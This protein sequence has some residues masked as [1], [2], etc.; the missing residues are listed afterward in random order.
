MGVGCQRHAQASLPWERP[1]TH[2]IL[3]IHFFRL[4]WS[5]LYFK[6]CFGDFN[7][8]EFR[9]GFICCFI[10][11]WFLS[12]SWLVF[13]LFIIFGFIVFILG[14]P[15]GRSEWVRKTS[16]PP[17]LDP[18][19]VQPVASRYTDCA[20]SV[21]YKLQLIRKYKYQARVQRWHTLFVL[22]RT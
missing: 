16:S 3:H 2:C 9:L 5:L 17:G 14:G 13:Y 18:R 10:L 21:F 8:S 20:I 12:L 22:V 7:L 1:C 11:Y 6:F 19:T 15:Q 4:D